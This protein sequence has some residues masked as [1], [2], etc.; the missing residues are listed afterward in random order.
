MLC[1][2]VINLERKV[3]KGMLLCLGGLLMNTVIVCNNVIPP[4]N[5]HFPFIYFK[6]DDES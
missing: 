3:L 2:M 5:N 6:E 1:S 4:P